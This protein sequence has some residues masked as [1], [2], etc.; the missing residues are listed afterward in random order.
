[1]CRSPL[2]FFV[3]FVGADGRAVLAV[4]ETGGGVPRSA[5]VQK[6]THNPQWNPRLS[7]SVSPMPREH[8]SFSEHEQQKAHDF[9]KPHMI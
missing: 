2:S 1:M 3:L 6:L 8:L 9:I 4:F 5:L 7:P